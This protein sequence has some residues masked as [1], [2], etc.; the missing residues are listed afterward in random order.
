MPRATLERRRILCDLLRA[1]N[2]DAY[3]ERNDRDGRN[4][5]LRPCHDRM[6]KI[7]R[8]HPK[9]RRGGRICGVCDSVPLCQGDT[10]A[11]MGAAQFAE[12]LYPGLVRLSRAAVPDISDG[13]LHP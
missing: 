7:W 1:A 12:V 13:A 5:G 11:R 10:G 3:S 6:A 8:L 9:I 2:A 4:D